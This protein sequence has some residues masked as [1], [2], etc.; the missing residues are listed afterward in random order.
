MQNGLQLPSLLEKIKA[1]WE[2]RLR[3]EH[4]AFSYLKRRVQPLMVRD[5]LGYEYTAMKIHIGWRRG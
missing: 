2:A 5:L 4:V 1:L 3:A